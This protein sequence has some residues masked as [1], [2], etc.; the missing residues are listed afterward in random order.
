[1][2]ICNCLSK[3]LLVTLNLI[4]FVVGLVPLV[5]GIIALVNEELLEKALK[6]IPGTEKITDIVDITE[7]CR[8]FAIAFIVLGSVIVVIGFFGFCGACCKSRIMLSTYLGFVILILLAE[9]TLIIIAVGFPETFNEGGEALL[10]LNFKDIS[11]CSANQTGYLDCGTIANSL[12][13]NTMQYELKCCGPAGISDYS[14]TSKPW[15]K[16]E[17]R[18]NVLAPATCCRHREGKLSDA[19]IN[20]NDFKTCYDPGTDENE[21]YQQGCFSSLVDWAVK[22]PIFIGVLAGLGA[23]ELV[24]I[25]ATIAMMH[26]SSSKNSLA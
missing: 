10:E 6:A 24:L 3:F 14:K 19:N 11:D 7:L 2:S 23:L 16:R 5:V 15:T 12:A 26:R 25:F 22:S 13:W 8:N 1:M 21:Y 20:D 17:G 4:F 18:E 9:I